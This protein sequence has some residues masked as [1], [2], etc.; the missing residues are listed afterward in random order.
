M[1]ISNPPTL[2]D[3]DLT[4]P[5]NYQD[6]QIWLKRNFDIIKAMVADSSLEVARGRVT[7]ISAVNKF[8]RCDNVDNGSD[9]DIWDGANTTDTE[10]KIWV[11]PT[12]ARIHQIASSSAN[13]TA[14]G[15]GARTIKLYGLT[16]WDAKEV[17]E[18]IIMNGTSD[19][20]T[21]NAYVII[22]RIKV[23]TFGSAGPNVGIITATADTNATVTAKI[24]AGA[25]Q[26]QMAIYGVPSGQTAYCTHYY[27]SAIKAATALSVEIKL[28]CNVQP[29]NELVG[30]LTK[31]T[32]GAATEGT[33]NLEHFFQPYVGYPGPAILKIQCNSSSNNTDVSAGF[34][35]YLIDD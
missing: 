15:T 27:A 2:D 11:A 19:V 28:L 21:A 8:G 4:P 13:D 1:A 3:L 14:A 20:P 31:H 17:S 24:M 25:G 35:L 16:S 6:L 9:S 26:T 12:A 29:D 23:E 5:D 33:S 10:S 18:T 7:G 32:L 22:H 30:F 34:D